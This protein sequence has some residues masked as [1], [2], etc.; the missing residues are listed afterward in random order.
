MDLGYGHGSRKATSKSVQRQLLVIR[1][2]FGKFLGDVGTGTA[3]CVI[4]RE[5]LS[6]TCAF[7]NKEP[8]HDV[9]HT[10]ES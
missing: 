3:K 4:H 1:R 10:R 5:K 6:S 7:N 8:S 9:C 2:T